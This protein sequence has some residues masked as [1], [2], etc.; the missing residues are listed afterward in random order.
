MFQNPY[1]KLKFFIL[2]RKKKKNAVNKKHKNLEKGCEKQ[3]NILKCFL[4][5]IFLWHLYFVYKIG[6]LLL[7]IHHY[8]I[9]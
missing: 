8:H 1:T 4:I 3:N 7:Y 6:I 2:K 9:I 5:G